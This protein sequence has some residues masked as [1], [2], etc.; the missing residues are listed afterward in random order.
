V[1]CPDH[2]VEGYS[3][4][5]CGEQFVGTRFDDAL[6]GMDDDRERLEEPGNRAL[7]L[8]RM[9]GQERLPGGHAMKLDRWGLLTVGGIRMKQS[10]AQS[11]EKFDPTRAT[12]HDDEAAR[13]IAGGRQRRNELFLSKTGPIREEPMHGFDGQAVFESAGD[14]AKAGC[15]SCIERKGVE[16]ERGTIL[17]MDSTLDEIDPRNGCLNELGTC[18]PAERA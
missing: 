10:M 7:D 16:S 9:A 3:I 15:G 12:A 18:E 14:F 4:P 13:A 5:R 1:R 8:P 6:A 17:Q 2:G 11:Q